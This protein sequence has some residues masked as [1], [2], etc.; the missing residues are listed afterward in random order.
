MVRGGCKNAPE[1]GRRG[2]G[3]EILA[4]SRVRPTETGA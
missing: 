1:S 4:V 2:F 3:I